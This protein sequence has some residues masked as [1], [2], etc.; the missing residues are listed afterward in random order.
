MPNHLR[1]A[2]GEKIDK[3]LTDRQAFEELLKENGPD[4]LR[5]HLVP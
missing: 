2:I 3:G 4:L 5:P 1:E